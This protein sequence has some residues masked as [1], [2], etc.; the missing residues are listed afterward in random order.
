ME[1]GIGNSAQQVG[2]P[3]LVMVFDCV[4]AL[5]VVGDQKPNLAVRI[6]IEEIKRTQICL[7]RSQPTQAF[8]SRTTGGPLVRQ[9]NPLR[10]VAETHAGQQ[11]GSRDR[12]AALVEPMTVDVDHRCG[13]P[14]QNA[15]LQP[16]PITPRGERMVVTAAPEVDAF[17]L[18]NA[19][20]GAVPRLRR[21]VVGRSDERSDWTR[22]TRVEA[23]S[24]QGPHVSHDA[25]HPRVAG[26]SSRYMNPFGPGH[27]CLTCYRGPVARERGWR[28]SGRYGTAR[29]GD[30]AAA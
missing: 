11:P 14:A 22:T 17:D 29:G 3:H 5:S 24:A 16:R 9:D 21:D 18:A 13:V 23:N 15:L 27:A 26:R 4:T 1:C 25:Q 19:E 6:P 2:A 8:L 7:H 28:E 12:P 30:C 20:L 10:P